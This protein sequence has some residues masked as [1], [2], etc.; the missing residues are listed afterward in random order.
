[1]KRLI[2]L[3]LSAF[4]IVTLSSCGA[5]NHTADHSD[6]SD[7][8]AETTQDAAASANPTDK[9]WTKEEIASLFASRAEFGW[10]LTDCVCVSDRAFDRV[11]VAV[12]VDETGCVQLAFLDAEGYASLC[13]IKQVSD[14]SNLAYCGNGVVTLSAKAQDGTIYEYKVTYSKSEDGRDTNFKL[15]SSPQG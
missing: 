1:V 12:F 7:Y 4:L 11:G 3:L 8:D 9:E 15:D 14:P 2:S 10:N 6:H 5:E 13:G